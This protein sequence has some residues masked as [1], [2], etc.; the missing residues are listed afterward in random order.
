MILFCS[1]E[2]SQAHLLFIFFLFSWAD[3]PCKGQL[4]D[5]SQTPFANHRKPK[6]CHWN[7]LTK[8]TCHWAKGKTDMVIGFPLHF[9]YI[10]LVCSSFIWFGSL[11]SFDFPEWVKINAKFDRCSGWANVTHFRFSPA[12]ALFTPFLCARKSLFVR[13]SVCLYFT[14]CAPPVY[15]FIFQINTGSF[16][17]SCFLLGSRWTLK[18]WIE[19]NWT[20]FA[21]LRL[22]LQHSDKVVLRR[23]GAFG[24]AYKCSNIWA[25]HRDFSRFIMRSQWS[26]RRQ[27]NSFRRII[28][29]CNVVWKGTIVLLSVMLR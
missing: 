7:P 17:V 29:D 24:I 28:D 21:R 9:I 10:F 3:F 2:V 23:S 27:F 25:M 4:C 13:L 26:E 6:S 5:Y 18:D 12:R 11:V 20:K 1:A 16:A 22:Q 8:R 19:L 14:I 15:L